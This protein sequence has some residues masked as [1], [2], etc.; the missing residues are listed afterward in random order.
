M[1]VRDELLRATSEASRLV[2]RFP[3]GDRTSIDVIGVLRELGFPVLC[4][5]LENL[6]GA[7]VTLG[8]HGSGVLVTTKLPLSVQRFTLAHE[9][10]H[11]MLGHRLQFDESVGEEGRWSS[12]GSS[13]EERAANT[14]AS[15]LLAPRTLIR[16]IAERQGW[17]KA[18]LQRPQNI[19]QLSLRLGMSFKAACWALVSHQVL[20]RSAAHELA[21]N[22]GL[23]KQIKRRLAPSDRLENPWADVWLL[24]DG[25]SGLHIEAGPD[26]IFAVRVEERASAGYVWEFDN[27]VQEFA[28]SGE[29][30][31]LPTK[32]GS[33]TERVVYLKYEDGGLHHLE[34]SHRRPWSQ[35]S[36]GTLDV[37][38]DNW[39]KEEPG[40][41][42]QTRAALLAGGYT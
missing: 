18:D 15:E 7:T 16:T 12:H 23:V 2:Q 5:P 25:D 30:T 40:F 17:K 10:G 41:P 11:L 26:D 20:S 9:L 37:S 4:R 6:W 1:N 35:E 8:E 33:P 42:R 24:S 36:I 27:S 39:G 19:Y 32:Y 29:E 21:N 31:N 38:I 14:F 3:V 28:I 22:N 13:S 34:L